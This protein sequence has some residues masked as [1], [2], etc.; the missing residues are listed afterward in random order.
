MEGYGERLAQRW[1]S[2]RQLDAGR[3]VFVVLTLRERELQ[4]MPG[5]GLSHLE[6]E[7]E[8]SG[9][10]GSSPPLFRAGRYFE[11]LM[12]LNPAIDGLIRKEDGSTRA[13]A[14][15]TPCYRSC[16]FLVHAGA[17]RT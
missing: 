17:P 15:L 10:L 13:P 9:T 3:S 1:R 2:E 5:E 4:V 11:A 16:T 6:K 12:K 8:R 7:L 14:G